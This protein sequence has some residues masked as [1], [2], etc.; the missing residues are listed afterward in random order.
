MN[1]QIENLLHQALL[2]MEQNPDIAPESAFKQ[3]IEE[4]NDRTINIIAFMEK[5]R[6]VGHIMQGYDEVLNGIVTELSDRT[7]NRINTAQ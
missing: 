7:Y 1:N 5:R 4:D 3:A 6:R 2:L